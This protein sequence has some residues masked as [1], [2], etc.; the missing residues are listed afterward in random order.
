MS[1]VTATSASSD[2][3]QPLPVSR[4]HPLK[5]RKLAEEVTEPSEDDLKWVAIE[6]MKE[7]KPSPSFLRYDL[8]ATYV[9]SSPYTDPLNHL[10]LPE[11]SRP[12]QLF[13]IALT[14]FSPL[15]PDY[16]TSL[17]MSTF[18]WL[19]IFLL[20]RRLCRHIGI[21]WNRSEFYV[22]IFRS[23]LR[24]GADQNRLAELDEMSHQ[25][26]CASG[27]LLHYWFGSPDV[28]RKNL[29]TCKLSC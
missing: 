28:E 23:T 26:A 24:I 3:A 29:A 21:R 10:Y 9:Q 15:Y 5:R 8:N 27:G 12:L 20:L 22:V 4:E 25:E 18:N 2:V 6:E 1:Q 19:N 17:Y 16:T 14:Q 7:S 13:A 11:L